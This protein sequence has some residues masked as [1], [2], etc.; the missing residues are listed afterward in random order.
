MNE[1][2]LL[3]YEFCSPVFIS[4]ALQII[5]LFKFF[6]WEI[7]YFGT[8][9]VMHDRC[10]WMICWG[11]LSWVFSVYT[12]HTGVIL[13]NKLYKSNLN[14]NSFDSNMNV[15]IAVCIFVIGILSIYINYEADAQKIRARKSNGKCKIFGKKADI[16]RATYVSDNGKNKKSILLVSGY[17]GVARHFHYIP[18]L[19][20]A[21]M[22]CIPNVTI[23]T[24]MQLFYFIFL[25]L[26]LTDRAGRDDVRCSNK[27]GLFWREYRKKVPYKLIPY[28]W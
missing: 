1:Y 23:G 25:V 20:F 27:Y 11:C 16:I 12:F 19:I 4:G 5:Y 8:L 22:I 21:F 7:G 28:I 2:E 9:D 15:F 18:E 24:S 26:L 3:I 13:S 10:G 17:W 14:N 6:W